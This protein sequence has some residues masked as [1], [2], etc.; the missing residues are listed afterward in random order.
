M[1]VNKN[2]ERVV[3]NSGIFAWSMTSKN[4]KKYNMQKKVFLI[5]IPEISIP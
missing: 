3:S 5:D 4:K 1:M 2:R